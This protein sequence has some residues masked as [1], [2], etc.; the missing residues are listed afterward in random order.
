[1]DTLLLAP[2]GSLSARRASALAL[3]LAEA[4]RWPLS[5]M[6]AWDLPST[7]LAYAPSELVTELSA[8]VRR[9][10]SARAAATRSR[11]ETS[12]QRSI[13]SSSSSP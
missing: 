9:S 13:V 12:P 10:M 4:T 1:M 6:S 5:A 11:S 7:A 2:D 8:A 3:D